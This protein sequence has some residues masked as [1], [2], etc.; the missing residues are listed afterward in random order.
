MKQS[1]TRFILLV[2]FSS[3]LFSSCGSLK[4]PELKSIEIVEL[5]RTAGEGVLKVELT[6]SNP[7]SKALTIKKVNIDGLINQKSVGKYTLPQ[8]GRID[9]RSEETVEAI[10]NF[11]PDYIY[12]GFLSKQFGAIGSKRVRISLKGDV[13]FLKEETEMVLPIDYSEIYKIKD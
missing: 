13:E 4:E 8:R 3:F 5:S 11:V 10:F 7:N 12:N 1:T 9:K 6:Y 2:T